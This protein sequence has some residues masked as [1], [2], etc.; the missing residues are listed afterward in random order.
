MPDSIAN[1][2]DSSV[3]IIKASWPQ[4]FPQPEPGDSTVAS[5]TTYPTM[6]V[7]QAATPGKPVNTPLRDTGTMGMLL[8]ALLMVVLSY[9]T[10]YKYI[11][12]FIK[13]L[14]SAKKREN[15]LNDRTA[16]ETQILTALTLNTCVMESILIFN[17]IEIFVPS[18]SQA[19]HSHVF[20]C[21]G[22]F[23][24]IG[25]IFYLAQLGVFTLV[26][27]VFSDAPS[28]RLWTDG[29][30]SA[31]SA[32]GLVLFPIVGTLLVWP[33]GGKFLLTVA[34]FLYILCRI[35]FIYKGFRIF[36][37]NLPSL[38]YFILYLC[39]VEIVPLIL[40]SAGSVYL[41]KIICI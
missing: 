9:R 40:L 21:T 3:V 41:C 26:G 13:N 24:L 1:N 20:A 32:L 10:G 29:F 7:P 2:I 14:F 12:N 5:M 28:T 34:I 18:L 15:A 30:K 39:S 19:M 23:M 22:P 17:A 4:G 31:H 36:Y 27:H 8:V 6:E 33:S 25:I 16:N 38:V 11:E 35:T 37:N